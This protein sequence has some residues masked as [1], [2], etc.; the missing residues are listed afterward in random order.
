MILGKVFL[1]ILNRLCQKRYWASLSSFSYDNYVRL[2]AVH[3]NIANLQRQ[4]LID[5]HGSRIQKKQKR[6]ITK[7]NGGS[8]CARS[9][10]FL[11]FFHSAHSPPA[12]TLKRM[13][14][15]YL[16]GI[17]EKRARRTISH[18]RLPGYSYGL[19][20]SKQSTPQCFSCKSNQHSTFRALC[21]LP[22]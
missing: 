9:L 10:S 4:K 22:L 15:H 21:L 6:V 8:C 17:S 18:C 20:S 16:I 3:G 11:E 19:F 1:Q 13:I 12:G 5:A 14:C 2:C 7:T